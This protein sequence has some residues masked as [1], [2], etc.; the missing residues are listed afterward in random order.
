LNE[1]SGCSIQPTANIKLTLK[2][3]TIMETQFISVIVIILFSAAAA[4]SIMCAAILFGTFYSLLF[5]VLFF[6]NMLVVSQRI[7]Y[8]NR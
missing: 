7:Q 4:V 2:T 3:F 6:I 5:C 1:N 8:I